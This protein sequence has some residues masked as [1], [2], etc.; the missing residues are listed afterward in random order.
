LAASASATTQHD[1]INIIAPGGLADLFELRVRPNIATPTSAGVY[2]DRMAS[3]GWQ[4]RWP[5]LTIES[6]AGGPLG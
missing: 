1:E 3:K 2:R 4:E 6:L 5:L